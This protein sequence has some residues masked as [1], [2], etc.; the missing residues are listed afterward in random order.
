MSGLNQDSLYPEFEKQGEPTVRLQVETGLYNGMI[1]PFAI[2][3][4]ADK[5]READQRK[6]AYEHQQLTVGR[7]AE[8]A[9]WL[10]AILAGVGIAV[11]IL[12]WLFPRH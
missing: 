10:A 1:M 12:A 8:R 3:W 2:R 9:A 5:Q 7:S 4:L 6:A 11:G